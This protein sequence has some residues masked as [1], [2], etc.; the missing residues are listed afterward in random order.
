MYGADR[1]KELSDVV[2]VE[3]KS[4]ALMGMEIKAVY[5]YLSGR[6]EGTAPL[7]FSGTVTVMGEIHYAKEKARQRQFVFHMVLYNSQ[8]QVIGVS[9][10][11]LTS[12]PILDYDVFEMNC[13]IPIEDV[14]QIRLYPAKED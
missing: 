3:S 11:N 1:K 6:C 7:D 2:V 8:D 13:A 9:S 5:A 4:A 14:H 12:D 10:S